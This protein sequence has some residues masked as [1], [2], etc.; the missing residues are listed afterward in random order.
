[1]A[2]KRS[3]TQRRAEREE[4][5]KFLT[6]H[7]IKRQL[8][9]ADSLPLTINGINFQEV[10]TEWPVSEKSAKKADIVLLRPGERTIFVIE[11]K[12]IANNGRLTYNISPFSLDV[13]KQAKGYAKE[14]KT[15]YYATFNGKYFVAFKIIQPDS[16]FDEPIISLEILNFTDFCSNLLKLI[17]NI[18]KNQI[19]PIQY[20]DLYSNL[21]KSYLDLLYT[22]YLESLK[23]KL[24]NIGKSSKF[25]KVLKAHMESIDRD[26]E[27][28]KDL[29]KVAKEATYILIDK[30][31][32]YQLLYKT[33]GYSLKSLQKVIHKPDFSKELRF[34]FQSVVDEINFSPIF[35]SGEILFTNVNEKVKNIKNYDES[36][37]VPLEGFKDDIIEFISILFEM[38][39]SK[40]D[41]MQ[42]GY[43]FEKVIPLE[44]RREL[45]QYYTPKAIIDLIN[46]LTIE[47]HNAKVFD[48]ACG[49]G[50]FLVGAYRLLKKLKE[51]ASIPFN[52]IT[53]LKQISGNDINRFPTHLSSISLAIQELQLLTHEVEIINENF[54]DIFGK[55]FQRF[56]TK[57]ST[58][59]KQEERRSIII[60][61]DFDAIVM[62]PPY[63]RQEKLN[64]KLVTKHLNIK[65]LQPILKQ[66]PALKMGGRS[67]IFCYF[68]T[69]SWNFLKEGGKIG[70]IVSDR[71]LDTKYGM[72]FQKIIL[73]L[74]QIEAIIAFETQAFE[75]PLVGSVIV[76]LK[77]NSN[78]KERENN[79]V[80]FLRLKK[81][82]SINEIVELIKND[83]SRID[84]NN[85]EYRMFYVNQ[86]VLEY[87]SKW[88]I[89]L[90]YNL[91]LICFLNYNKRLVEITNYTNIK[92]G[93]KSGAN[94]FFFQKYEEIDNDLKSYFSPLLKALGQVDKIQY[95]ENEFEWGILNI[96]GILKKVEKKYNEY[97]QKMLNKGKIIPKDKYFYKF[98]NKQHPRLYQYI[99]QGELKKYHTRKST[100]NREFWFLIKDIKPYEICL[101]TFYWRI[102]IN[103]IK[104]CARYSIGNQLIYVQPKKD[105][106][107]YR[108]LIAAWL[109]TNIIHFFIEVLSRRAKGERL[110]RCQLRIYEAKM[111][112]CPDFHLMDKNQRINIKKVWK[113]LLEVDRIVNFREVNLDNHQQKIRE[114][115]L[116]KI[117]ELDILFL[118]F[119][120]P[121]Q[122]FINQEYED[123]ELTDLY[124]KKCYKFYISLWNDLINTY[125]KSYD[126]FI[127]QIL[128]YIIDSNNDMLKLREK[129]GKEQ[130][131]ETLKFDEEPIEGAA[132]INEDDI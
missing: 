61:D 86:K 44:D 24:R 117:I 35:S 113:E 73:R 8:E 62:N 12:K 123:Q 39:L 109:N 114:K 96:E 132:L 119:I 116:D 101:S 89:F 32:F 125:G 122:I 72:K 34:L 60:A 43:I 16:D 17:S 47:F 108:K 127:K 28:D 37:D 94:D 75:E 126:D 74:Y 49:S 22:Q 130:Q 104:T 41:A 124:L 59:D 1:M 7:Y 120:Y 65:P 51:E 58:A 102:F 88:S 66:N 33:K 9:D 67:D 6:A 13:I 91:A 68:I 25:Y 77:K 118:K 15:D 57:V 3:L 52:H 84:I 80:K 42:L 64:T 78:K 98:L 85:E 50:G 112:P 100:K 111:L 92:M 69:H 71:W 79:C 99:K 40:L 82:K 29:E 18:I 129:G 27:N 31:L 55:S 95:V 106:W 53:L 30:L 38:D 36:F 45:G 131:K 4:K 70:T 87:N 26:I 81:K 76:I 83:I 21:L 115:W 20:E 23:L 93:H 10:E 19:K 107:K 14:L 128:Q 11:T 5:V 121:E 97:F 90:F 48:P 2:K 105:K 54:F 103:P 110:D 56:S 63:L 46:K